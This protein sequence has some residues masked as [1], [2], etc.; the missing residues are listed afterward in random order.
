[1]KL[2]PNEKVALVRLAMELI[3]DGN[4]IGRAASSVVT[5]PFSNNGALFWAARTCSKVR[6]NRFVTEFMNTSDKGVRIEAGQVVGYAE[7]VEDAAMDEASQATDMFCYYH[8]GDLSPDE[9]TEPEE[10]EDVEEILCD[11][12]PSWEKTVHFD[13]GTSAFTE[14]ADPGQPSNGIPG[15]KPLRMDYSDMAEDA[16]PYTERLKHLIEVKHEK[17]FSKHDRD[18]GKTT[19]I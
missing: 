18:Y 14:T 7:F 19:L 5:E 10:D 13:L 12:L 2:Q 3:L 4:S 6:G 1:M 9:I 17:A 15:A 8:S 11:P 16:R